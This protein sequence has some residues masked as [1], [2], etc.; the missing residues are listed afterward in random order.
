MMLIDWGNV[1]VRSGGGEFGGNTW[2]CFDI[3]CSTQS[4]GISK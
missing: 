1:K 3:I 4:Y 2:P